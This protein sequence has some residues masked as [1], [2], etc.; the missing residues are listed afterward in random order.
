MV[1]ELREYI[2]LNKHILDFKII[3][4]INHVIS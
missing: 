1:I 4:E 2:Y 3:L